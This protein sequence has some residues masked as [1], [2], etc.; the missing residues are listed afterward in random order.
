M[1]EFFA[2]SGYAAFVWSAYAIT[3]G[4]LLLNVWQARRHLQ[5]AREAARRKL[6]MQETTP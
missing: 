6:A 5:R 4:G 1:N 2:M 3:I